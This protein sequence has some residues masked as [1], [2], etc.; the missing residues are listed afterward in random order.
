[1]QDGQGDAARDADAAPH[2]AGGGALG[3]LGWLVE[4]LDAEDE[5]PPYRAGEAGVGALGHEER[6]PL[7][8]K[9]PHE[10]GLWGVHWGARQLVH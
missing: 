1:M 4:K 6:L 9:A 3:A 2:D 8:D 5:V 10:L 7:R